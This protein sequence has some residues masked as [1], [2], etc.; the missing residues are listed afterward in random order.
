LSIE[1]KAARRKWKNPPMFDCADWTI[2]W[3]NNTFFFKITLLLFLSKKKEKNYKRK[4][5]QMCVRSKGWC[6]R[7]WYLSFEFAW[8][9]SLKL[10]QWATTLNATKAFSWW[11]S[12]SL[13]TTILR[14]VMNYVSWTSAERCSLMSE[15]LLASWILS[16]KCHECT[17]L[18]SR[19]GEY[20]ILWFT[21]RLNIDYIT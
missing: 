2:L 8:H 1:E 18:F 16:S 15:H 6:W 13:K 5:L 14:V 7:R 9:V 12:H 3:S 17:P 10:N 21:F 19:V 20:G 4:C 11:C